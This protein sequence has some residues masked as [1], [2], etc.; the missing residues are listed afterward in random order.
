MRDGFSWEKP[1][2]CPE[3]LELYRLAAGD[4]R[5]FIKQASCN[6]SIASDGCFAAAMIAEFEKPLRELGAWFYPRLHWECGMIGQNLYLGAEMSGL[7]GCGIGCYLD[8]TVH[9]MLG[10]KDMAY[11][12]L[13][14]FTAGYAVDDPR[15][16][17]LPAYG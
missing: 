6:Q 16:T 12:D 3:S 14:H 9:E 1:A 8:D 17:T 15:L 2:A 13:Y 11:Q 10:I 5:L 4:I 7:R